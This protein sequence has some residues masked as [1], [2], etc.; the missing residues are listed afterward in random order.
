MEES[1]NCLEEVVELVL[2]YQNE[3]NSKTPDEKKLNAIS[4][5]IISNLEEI[6]LDENDSSYFQFIL[7]SLIELSREENPVL[8]FD[9][10]IQTIYSNE[11]LYDSFD[12]IPK[13]LF[14][15]GK[16]ED[17]TYRI[18]YFFEQRKAQN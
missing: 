4:D 7:E 15:K 8:S 6:S 17:E 13:N 2:A 18:I 1:R 14:P 5:K 10:L 3:K 11:Y 12:K 16:Y 9:K